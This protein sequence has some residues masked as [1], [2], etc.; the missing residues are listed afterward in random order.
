MLIVS[1]VRKSES[2]SDEKPF[3]VVRFRKGAKE[4]KFALGALSN[5]ASYS[6]TYNLELIY[7]AADGEDFSARE[8]WKMFKSEM[9]IGAEEPVNGYDIPIS[10]ISE[11]SE[12]KV[13]ATGRIMSVMRPAVYGTRE[14]AIAI[15]KASLER[16]LR[17]KTFKVVSDADADDDD[18]D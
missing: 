7:P 12:V 2:F 14:D 6:L 1:D 17:N 15:C 5:S 11:F 13:V 8:A 16:Q 4:S 3:A 18:D 10:E 9:K